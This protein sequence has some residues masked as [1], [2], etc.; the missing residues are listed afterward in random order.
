MSFLI[1]GP[2]LI[3]RPMLDGAI[4]VELHHVLNV[5]INNC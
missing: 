5:Q 1:D 3:D 2:V 4:E